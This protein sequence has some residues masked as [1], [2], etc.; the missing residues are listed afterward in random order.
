MR[1]DK[2]K[3]YK[4]CEKCFEIYSIQRSKTCC[5]KNQKNLMDIMKAIYNNVFKKEVV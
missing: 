1:K 4:I 5:Q 3:G 2:R